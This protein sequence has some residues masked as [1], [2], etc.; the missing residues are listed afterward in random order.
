MKGGGENNKSKSNNGNPAA[1]PAPENNN[2]E[3]YTPIANIYWQEPE[4]GESSENEDEFYKKIKELTDM[5]DDIVYIKKYDSGNR[6][7]N[8]EVEI[9]FKDF[10]KIK[11]NNK[12]YKT[13]LETL[14]ELLKYF[15]KASLPPN[16]MNI[17]VMLYKPENSDEFTPEYKDFL[18]YLNSEIYR[19]NRTKR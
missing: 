14:I 8:E 16:W 6:L 17:N 3:I 13:K 5:N 11:K 4:P 7:V 9:H 19:N 12:N 1:V 10:S 15:I 18:T 2:K